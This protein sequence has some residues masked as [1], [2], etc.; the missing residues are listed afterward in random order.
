MRFFRKI[1]GI[2]GFGNH[3]HD[4]DS[5]DDADDE[6]DAQPRTTPYRVRETGPR[7]GFSVPAQVVVDRPHLAPVLT[8]SI[9]GDG[10]L[11]GLRWY[12][13][14]LKMDED[15]DVA[16]EFLDEVSSE[17]PEA[18]AVDHHKTTARFKLKN[19]TKPANVKKQIL[20]DGKII[21]Q[22]AEDKGRLP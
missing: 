6:H 21:P 3:D 5:K 4:H 13:K 9:S 19:D 8:P 2:L 16:D 12:V 14:R 22:F 15:G 1:I 11:Q 18:L 20:L 7:K 10:G 17:M